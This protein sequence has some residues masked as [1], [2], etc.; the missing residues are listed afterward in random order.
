MADATERLL[1]LETAIWD[2]GL[3]S[4]QADQSTG[5]EAVVE[6]ADSLLPILLRHASLQARRLAELPREDLT[7]AQE[8]LAC[9]DRC[10]TLLH[11]PKVNREFTVH[12]MELAVNRLRSLLSALPEEGT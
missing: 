6:D 12:A 9:L 1:A 5:V 4:S 3:P 10:L 11:N 2:A 8:S 7:V